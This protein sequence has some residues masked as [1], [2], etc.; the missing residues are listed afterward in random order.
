MNETVTGV[1]NTPKKI[2][3]SPSGKGKGKAANDPKDH[4]KEEEEEEEEEDIGD[5]EMG[6]DDEE[7]EDDD[8]EVS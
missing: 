4:N 1:D 2:N 3:A 8:E 5:D 6:S 7:E